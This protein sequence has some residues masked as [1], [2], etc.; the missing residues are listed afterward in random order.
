MTAWTRPQEIRDR[1]LKLWN[2]GQFLSAQLTGEP[3]FP[4]RMPLKYPTPREL[5]DRYGDVKAWIDEL[6]GQAGSRR[7]KTYDLEWREINHRQ[8]GRNQLPVA[9]IFEQPSD[10]LVFIGKQKSAMAFEALCRRIVREV[11][12]LEPWLVRK[13]LI[14]LRHE[15]SWTGLLAVLEWLRGHPRPGIYIR[16]LEIT[17]IDTKFIER[18][19]KLLAE[20][21]DIVLP[22]AAIDPRATGAAG[23]EQRY[24]FLAK[25]AQIRF[26]LLDPDLFIAGL[27]DLQIPA[28]DFA[29]FD[30]P[31]VER[32][33][34]TENDINGLAFPQV[35]N[36]MVV[37]G[38]GY[39]LERLAASAWL[40]GKC[41]YYWGDIDTHGFAMLDQ[42]RHYFPHTRSLLMDLH[43]LM[44]H[45]LLWGSER[46][47]LNRDLPFLNP[48]EAAVYE[49]LRQ[50]QWAQA[51]RLEQERVSY[52]ALKTTLKG[53]IAA[54]Q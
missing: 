42:I 9:A 39:G 46:A 16:Q 36:A 10:A 13:P 21:L 35:K 15:K 47:P 19:K 44:D 2:R 7:G 26:R 18:Y 38:L 28:D 37:F 40:D 20:L 14:A 34:I 43:T 27:S 24:G 22:A 3:L 33:F 52:T 25:P 4:L 30:P 32:I 1:L 17:G 50:N 5:A 53:S 49:G 8:L 51:L 45:R 54:I 48:A 11:P 6:V 12:D 41:L 23:F 29:R 31:G